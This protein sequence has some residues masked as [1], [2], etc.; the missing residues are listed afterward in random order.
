MF[1]D[2]KATAMF[3]TGVGAALGVLTL[4]AVGTIHLFL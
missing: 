1:T 4:A 2:L 3:F